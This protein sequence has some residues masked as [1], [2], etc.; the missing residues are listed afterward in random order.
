MPVLEPGKEVEY[1]YW[2]GCSASYDKRNQSIARAVVRI[3]T[4]AKVSFGVMPEERCN[5]YAARVADLDADGR[6]EIVA[7]FA[8]EPA[9]RDLFGSPMEERCRTAGSLRVWKPVAKDKD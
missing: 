9:A 1:L 7:A 8:G 5:G 6:N 2:V 3:L 4:A